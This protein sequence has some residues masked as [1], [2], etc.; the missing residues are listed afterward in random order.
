ML[1]HRRLQ[2]ATIALLFAGGATVPLAAQDYSQQ[3]PGYGYGQNKVTEQIIDGLIGKRYNVTDRQPI[4]QCLYA[5]VN[6]AEYQYRGILRRNARGPLDAYDSSVQVLRITRVERRLNG[7]RVSGELD[8]GL[9]RGYEEGDLDFRCDVDE[10]AYVSN[11]KVSRNYRFA[12]STLEPV[13]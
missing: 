13:D 8:A 9:I 1:Q 10:R 12:G 11:V 7:L 5:A 6:R 4:R 2:M 3:A